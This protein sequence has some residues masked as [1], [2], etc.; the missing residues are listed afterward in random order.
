MNRRTPRFWQQAI[1]AAFITLVVGLAPH[2]S[3]FADSYPYF[4]T[5]DGGPFAGGWFNSGNNSCD[6]NLYQGP[7]YPTSTTVSNQYQGAIMAWANNNR[8]QSSRSNL[9]AFA[10]GL[11][12]GN[13]SSNYGFYTSLS[14]ANNQLSFSNFNNL[15][16]NDF[17][18]GILEGADLKT[19]CIPDYYGTKQANPLN[20]PGSFGAAADGQYVNNGNLTLSGVIPAGRQIVL[21]VNGNVTIGENITYDSGY[22]LSDVTK[23]A[24]VVKGDI[25]IEPSVTSLD[26]WY[27]AQPLNS[28]NG[29]VIWTCSNGDN[30]LPDT[31]IRANCNNTLNIRG[32]LTAKQVNLTRIAGNIGSATAAEVI[33]F[34]PEMVLGGPFFE[35]SSTNNNVGKIQS[36]ISLPPVF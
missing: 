15:N 16:V 7:T 35:D 34:T 4:R 20:W 8:D 32:A 17:W 13:T 18:G 29:G 21:F 6:P 19:H 10:L 26:G 9:D 24:L 11:I 28:T 5:A 12:E 3:A 31:Y 33:N 2:T 25:F 30:P 1:S 23:F 27:I 36:L 14:G 22:N